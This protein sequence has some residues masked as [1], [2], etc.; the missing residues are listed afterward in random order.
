MALSG[1]A[2]AGRVRLMLPTTWSVWKM[3]SSVSY[4]NLSGSAAMKYLNVPS[5]PRSLYPT[6]LAAPSVTLCQKRNYAKSKDKKSKDKKTKVHLSD[7]E[8]SEVLN[9]THM[10]NQFSE[11][12]ENL[13]QDYIKNLSLRTSAGSI[14]NLSVQLEGDEYPLNEVAQVSRKSSHMLV[15]NASAFPQALTG[16]IKAIQEAGMNLNPQQEGT[17]LYVPLP[18]VTKEHRENLAKNAKT[19]Y[20]RCKDQLRE[21]QNQYIR[22]AK[23][24]EGQVSEDLIHDVQQKVREIAESHMQEAEKMMSVKQKELLKTN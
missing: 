22:K 13:K 21:T 4:R 5:P 6:F 2:A 20:N 14:E 24:K 8:M 12:V 11:T 18:K 23:R 15:I 9:V 3:L 7:E 10:R 1:S 19:L 16:I 17:T